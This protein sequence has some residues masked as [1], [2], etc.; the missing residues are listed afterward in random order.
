MNKDEFL[1]KSLYRYFISKPA[2][3]LVLKI[4]FN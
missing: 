4:Y 3:L 2:N 1:P